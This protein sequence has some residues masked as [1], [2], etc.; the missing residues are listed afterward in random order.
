MK[1]ILALLIV[2]LAL[3]KLVGAEAKIDCPDTTGNT[4]VMRYCLNE[5][6]KKWDGQLNETYQDF[7]K[8]LKPMEMQF[9]NMPNG[10]LVEGLR[11]AQREWIAYRDRSCEFHSYVMY[12]GTLA[13]VYELDCQ[14]RMTKSRLEELKMEIKDWSGK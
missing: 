13:S 5:E 3:P 1:P 7:L 2:A 8:R 6:L 4:M 14:I 12:G 11:K 9:D 10:T